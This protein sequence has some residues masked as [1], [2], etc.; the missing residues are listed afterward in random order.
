LFRATFSHPDLARSEL[1]LLLP[2]EVR[3]HLDL[4]TLALRDG[5][6]IDEAFSQSHTDL[7]FSV[8]TKSG[9]AALIYVL[10]EHQ[11]TFDAAMPFRLLRYMVRIWDRCLQEQGGAIK[12][13]LIL[14]VVL[15]HGNVRWRAAP[16]LASM[17]EATPQLLEA[18]RPFVPHYRF[19]LDDLA[20]LDPAALSSRALSALPRLVQLALWASR[21]GPRLRAA[22][23]F[24]RAIVATLAGDE[25]TRTLL[26]QLFTYALRTSPRGVDLQS[27]RTILLDIAGP[28]YQEDVMNAADQLIAQGRAEGR[29]EG[30]LEGLRAAI[31]AALSARHILLSAAGRARVASCKDLQ[32]LSRWHTRAV[33]ATSEAQIFA[34]DP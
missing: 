5:S 14:P 28:P 34:A 7:L 23:P 4:G 13:P 11:S 17:L 12:L 19:V 29:A 15:H 8:A 25:R 22:A 16:E 33:T 6:S 18:T 20:A 21:S 1:E 3:A 31:T 32:A 27:V 10:L 9:S 30:E 26:K 24:M 2:P